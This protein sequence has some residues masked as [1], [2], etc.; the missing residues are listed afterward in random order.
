MRLRDWSPTAASLG[1]LLVLSACGGGAVTSVGTSSSSVVAPTALR[2]SSVVPSS[3]PVAGG[4]VV[5][6]TGAN[7]QSG[8]LVSFGAADASGVTFISGTQI[9][10]VTPPQPAGVVNVSV[11]NPDGQGATLAN[12]FTY[13]GTPAPAP[14]VNS[15]SPTSGPSGGGTATTINGAN[16]QS[17][18]TVSFGGISAPA[19]TV[20]STAQIQAVTPGVPAGTVDVT[21]TNP[22]GQSGTLASGFTFQGSLTPP[23]TVN[24]IS[25]S[26][27]PTVGGTAVTIIG[28]DF[29]FG[30]RVTFGGIDATGVTVSG[31][32]LIQAVTP[33][34]P[35]G[36]VDVTV[37]NPD[38]QS[39]TLPSGF[40]FQGPPPPPGISSISPNLGMVQGGSVVRITGT[41]FEPPPDV[42]TPNGTTVSFGG[43]PAIG[44]FFISSTELEVPAPAHAAG[45]VDV[46]VTNLD[47]QSAT[48]PSGF[49]YITGIT[50]S[51][52]LFWDASTSIDVI[53]YNAYRANTSGGPFMKLN[54]TL[55]PSTTL[56]FTDTFVSAGETLFYVVTAVNSNQVQGIHSNEAV[57]VIPVP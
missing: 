8:V 20:P 21:V 50:H 41:N 57:A 29:Q 34:N 37:I 46:T 25:P 45:P 24:S 56:T 51:V 28:A 9:Q 55:I 32:T 26:S 16:F 35:A 5:T 3:G 38:G 52:D 15:I 12:A 14:Q 44:E 11:L 39:G 48:L 19:V 2:L 36:T 7:F 43:V 4:T 10:A 31:T 33:G 6:L 23:P 22:D 27:G 1:F 47:G 13:T 49:T 53:G 17:G 42:F 40:T 30:A 18:A 54:S